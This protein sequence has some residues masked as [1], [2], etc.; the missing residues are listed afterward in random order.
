MWGSQLLGD[1]ISIASQN[2]AAF[3]DD[4]TYWMGVDS[5]YMYDGRVKALPC[6]LK[7]HV[8]NDINHFQIKQV[9]AGT[10]EGF[11]EVWWFYCSASSS[12][13]DKYVVYNHVQNIWY[14]GNLARSAWLDTGIRQF[15]V[16]ATYSKNIVTHEMV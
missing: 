16:A 9:F 1:N 11:D 8:F 6:S 5:F 13:V 3:A 12:T 4:V 14:F 15:P 7:R 2:A 10:N